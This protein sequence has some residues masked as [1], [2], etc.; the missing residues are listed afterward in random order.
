MTAV[1]TPSRFSIPRSSSVEIA[2]VS[3][4]P[5][6]KTTF[7]LCTYVA[8]SSCPSSENNDRS[9]GIATLF[10]SPRLTARSKAA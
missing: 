2:S 8:T 5:D 9:S 10:V 6:R 3:R 4:L 7:P 1:S